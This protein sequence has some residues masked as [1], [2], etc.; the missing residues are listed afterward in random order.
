M[1]PEQ[2][3]GN[4]A[5]VNSATDVYG[6]GAVLCEL[7]TGHPPF[8][9]GTT[10]ETIKLVL[11]AEP[12]PPRLWDRKIDRD[13]STICLKCL[14]KDPKRRYSSALALAEDLERWL[15]HEP[16]RARRAGAFTRGRKW[17]RRNPSIAV[18]A[19]MLL[20]L[21][22]P[23]GVIVWKSEFPRQPMTTGI[24]VLP[25]ENL[26][27]QKERGPFVDGVQDDI[28]T[29]L[30]KIAD[31]KV[32]SRTSVMGYRGNQNIRQ[33]GDQLRVSHVLEGSVRRVGAQL[34]MNMQLI[35]TRTDTHIWAEQYDRDLNDLFTIQSEIAQ[36]VAHQL[37]AKVTAA[38]KLAIERKPTGD[39]VA[40]DLYARAANL[41]G[42]TA[43]TITKLQLVQVIDL[44]NQAVARDPSFFG[45]YCQLAWT[46]LQLY[47]LGLDHTP[48]RL[49]LAEGA[50]QAASRLRPDDGETHVARGSNFYW[51][52]RDYGRALDELE[53]ARQ[54][55]PN[56]VDVF[57]MMGFVLRRQGRWE[58]ST[59][60][61]ERAIE[62]DPRN[63]NTYQQIAD[64]YKCL[65][66]YAE[67]KSTYDRAL[68]VEP[69]DVETRVLRALV[70]LDSKANTRPLHQMIDSIRATDPAA[71]PKGTGNDAW[72]ICALA[73]RDVAAARE[74][75]AAADEFPL[76]VDAVNF[77]RPFAEG[78]IAR[79]TNDE[80]K[81]QLAFTAARAEQEKTVQA[82]ADFGPAWCVL[83]VIDAALG[84]EEVALREGRRAVELLPVERDPFNGTLMIKYLA[85]IAAWVGEK[86][87][88][89]EQL[90]TAVRSPVGG[91]YLSYGDLKLMPFWDPLRGEPCFE[92]IVASLAPKETVSR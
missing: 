54:K 90:A 25:F 86:D 21:A 47:S 85:M 27:G 59:R 70:E 65:R 32:I 26:S 40:F 13:L 11:D 82:Q 73:E 4:N 37:R 33:I 39:L 7:L 84:Q 62:L 42:P 24:A 83:G 77:T 45:A 48:A 19:A 89:C 87:L 88:A 50:V 51:G 69:S 55:L 38:E 75:L 10:Y 44:L 6:I 34:H 72:L 79:M 74:A 14:E 43:G 53:I 22:V 36:K 76:G 71:M 52:H 30:A 16:I 64:S 2:A 91:A 28:L 15:K 5:A 46:H 56:S 61:L 58:E 8:A 18:M 17:V 63:I 78:V 49:A 1:A 80:Q 41:P 68:G 57:A 29:K 92:K 81:A 60:S 12:R 20:A 67:Q 3:V 31:L 23:L 9:G 35:D 66:R